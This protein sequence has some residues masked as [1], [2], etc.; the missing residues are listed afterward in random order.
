[1]GRCFWTVL[2]I[3]IATACVLTLH[4]AAN[5]NALSRSITDMASDAERCRVLNATLDTIH[6]LRETRLAIALELHDQTLDFATA[7]EQMREL[8]AEDPHCWEMIQRCHPGHT[9][10]ELLSYQLLVAADAAPWPIDRRHRLLHDLRVR[11]DRELPSGHVP[12]PL[13]FPSEADKTRR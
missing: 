7:L 11:C 4:H 2:G 3:G 10:E 6:R 12:I 8:N 5:E 13:G 1:M 9:E